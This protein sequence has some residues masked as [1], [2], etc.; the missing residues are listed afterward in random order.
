MSA[1]ARRMRDSGQPVK[2]IA[3]TMGVRRGTVYRHSSEGGD[4]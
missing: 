1:L 2:V 4:K 3:E